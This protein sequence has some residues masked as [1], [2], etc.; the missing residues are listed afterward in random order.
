VKVTI[1]GTEEHRVAEGSGPVD[2]L[3]GAMRKAIKNHYP[4]IGICT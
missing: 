2:S 1:D 3:D 4:A